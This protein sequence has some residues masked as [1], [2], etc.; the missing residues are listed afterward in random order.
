MARDGSNI[1]SVPP[2]TQ[3]V[4]TTAISSSSFNLLLSDIEALANEARPISAGGTGQTS[5]AGLQAVFNVAPRD[6]AATITGDW[7]FTGAVD[8]TGATVTGINVTPP[9]GSITLAKIDPAALS[10]DDATLLTGTAGADQRLSQ[11]NADGD[12]VEG[13]AYGTGASQLLQLDGVGALPA[14]DGSNLTNLPSPQKRILLATVTASNDPNIEFTQFDN[15]TYGVYELEVEAFSPQSSPSSLQVRTSSNGGTSYDTG[16]TAYSDSVDPSSGAEME[17]SGTIQVNPI[18]AVTAVYR[19]V[20]AGNT[21]T[22]TTV[23]SL[24]YASLPSTGSVDAGPYSGVRRATT[25]VNAI[26]IFF[27]NNIGS[28]VARLYGVLE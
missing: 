7:T 16:G 1:Y 6:S 2:G 20:N 25:E 14:V 10:G 5:V 24:S 11:F 18:G 13:P 4:S 28:G 8:L 22:Y 9:D 23:S 15:T 12:I 27:S 17:V 26:R 3:A 19:I 21:S